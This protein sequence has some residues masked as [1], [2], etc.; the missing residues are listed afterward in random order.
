MQVADETRTL[1][2]SLTTHA[3]TL[4]D[5]SR[6][7]LEVEELQEEFHDVFREPT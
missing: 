1:L 3:H 7:P 4:V 6:L 5:Q 2:Q